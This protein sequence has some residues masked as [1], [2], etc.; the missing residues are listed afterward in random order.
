MK[1]ETT[2]AVCDH[3]NRGAVVARTTYYNDIDAT[4]QTA[5]RQFQER[6]IL[7]PGTIDTRSIEHVR[8][9]DLRGYSR[10][11]F[12][13][14]CGAWDIALQLADAPDIDIWTGSCPCQPF[15]TAGKQKGTQDERHLWPTWRNLIAERRPS[16]VFGEQVA[17]PLGRAWL[18]A[19][20]AGLEALGYAVGAA[21]LCAAGVG[22]PHIRQRLLWGAVRL[23][24]SNR[25]RR[26]NERILLQPRE[27]NIEIAWRGAIDYW[28]GPEW[29][30]LSDNTIRPFESGVFPLADG[31]PDRARRL[32]LIGN[33]IVP[34]VAAIFVRAF[35]EAA[36]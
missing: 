9:A 1:P 20:R 17:S 36:R 6:G 30:V 18:A 7:S 10:C 8:P 29:A 13:A 2:S 12:F 34:Q 27:E 31:T 19:V 33:A 3:G 32:R 23:A 24:D 4:A 25:Q 26:D 14:G 21:D 22:A 16:I 35:L 5:I 28:A 15:S 11:H